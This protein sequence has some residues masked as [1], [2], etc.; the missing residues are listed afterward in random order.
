MANT[1]PAPAAILAPVFGGLLADASGYHVTF[2][3]S[4][5]SALIMAAMLWF[6]V[7]DPK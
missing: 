4:A 2:I 5:A 7:K 1:L 3:L 6:I